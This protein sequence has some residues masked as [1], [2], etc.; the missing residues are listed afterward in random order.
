[1]RGSRKHILDW[2]KQSCFVKELN[3]LLHSTNVVVDAESD[4]WMPNANDPTEARLECEEGKRLLPNGD[5]AD[6]LARWWLVHPRGANTPNWDLAASCTI[7]G[8]KGLVLVEAKAHK[9]ELDWGSKALDRNASPDSK[10]NHQRIGEAIEEAR[11]YLNQVLGGT[12]AIS[13]DDRYQFSNRVAYAWEL[14]SLGV[15][16]VLVYLGFIGDEYFNSDYFRDANHWRR[17]MG[18]YM[19]DLVPHSL[20]DMEV[21]CGQATFRLIISSRKVLQISS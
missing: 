15:P 17:A 16:V 18:D 1:V 9:G 20:P 2:V 10:E 4:H 14:A 19:Q 11:H 8:R 3:D 12:V 5:F 21:D 6:Q 13:R 7:R